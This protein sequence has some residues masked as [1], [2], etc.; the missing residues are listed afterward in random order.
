[1]KLL[2]TADWHLGQ[3]LYGRKRY[4][5]QEK[6]LQWLL[7]TIDAQ[8]VDVL[9][10]AGDIFDSAIPSNQA[11]QL[12]YQFLF[13]AA[14]S[15]C[16]HV[17]IVAGNHDSATFLEAPKT[18]LRLINVHVVGAMSADIADEVIVLSDSQQQ[19]Q[20]LIC[21]VPYLRDKDLR[22]TEAGEQLDAKNSKL[23]AGIKQHYTDVYALAQQ[24]QA[25]L[26][27]AHKVPIIAT[28]H[29][30]AQGA[31]T[32]AGDANSELLVGSLLRVGAD[33]F[34]EQL[35]YLA[36]GHLHIPQRVAGK[37]HL[38]YSGAPIATS[39]SEAGQD[40]SVVLVDF[41]SGERQISTL[42]IPCS[43]QLL[44]LSGDLAEIH[45]RIDALKCEQSQAWL[46]IDYT[47]E[48]M[49]PQL[50]A[51]LMRRVEDT[52]LEILRIRN[53]K[54]STDALSSLSEQRDLNDISAAQIFEH[55]LQANQVPE[56][57][58][59]ELR[60]YYRQVLQDLAGSSTG[61]VTGSAGVSPAV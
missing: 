12:Y 49:Q 52:E 21:A 37:E 28:G 35:D 27:A 9:L 14:K 59:P 38:R 7:A 40:K 50:R 46:E 10:V 44:R 20:A 2:H 48:Q 24:R 33:C 56:A 47:G 45:E 53:R 61:S 54:V 55:C 29:L 32:V 34:P 11:Q 23:L 5:E 58:R 6:F 26:S 42:T 3:R 43:Q 4:Q 57:D 19:P 15:H 17:V 25:Q 31:Q 22:S 16:Q 1:M 30:F 18:L 8:R 36:L 60:A 41:N 13:Q 39:Y 51:E